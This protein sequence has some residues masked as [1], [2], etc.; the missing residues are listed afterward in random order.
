MS[1]QSRRRGYEERIGVGVWLIL[2]LV[3]GC[4]CC[5]GERIECSHGVCGILRRIVDIAER[6]ALGA[7]EGSLRGSGL[8]HVEARSREV[9]EDDV[10]VAECDGE[11]LVRALQRGAEDEAEVAEAHLVVRAALLDLAETSTTTLPAPYYGYT[12]PSL[13]KTFLDDLASAGVA[14]ESYQSTDLQSLMGIL[15][16]QAKPVFDLT[17]YAR[18]RPD[19][20]WPNALPDSHGEAIRWYS[21]S[22]GYNEFPSYSYWGPF[23]VRDWIGYGISAHTTTGRI[24]SLMGGHLYFNQ[25][26]GKNTS[27]LSDDGFEQLYDRN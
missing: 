17:A 24:R 25:T 2:P 8:R 10:V 9:V 15:G 22:F 21:E 1:V 3:R 14:I 27:D 20:I 23:M 5:I 6:R 11:R 4:G 13:Q 18:I 7:R 12:V 16:V 19:W 26:E